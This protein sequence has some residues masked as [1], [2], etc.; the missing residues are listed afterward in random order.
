R[1]LSTRCFRR[2]GTLDGQLV[3][4]LCFKQPVEGSSITAARKASLQPHDWTPPT[5]TPEALA[6]LKAVDPASVE[7]FNAKVRATRAVASSSAPV[8]PRLTTDWDRKQFP[9]SLDLVVF[10]A[11]T[12]IAPESHIRLTLCP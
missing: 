6:R 9:E 10:E 12:R 11:T 8:P 1:L 4:L 3:L 7:R 5:F 2:G